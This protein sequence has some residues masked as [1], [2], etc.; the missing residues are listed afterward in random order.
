ME[1]CADHIRKLHR[2]DIRILKSLEYLMERY[3]LVPLEEIAS[4]TRLSQQEVDFRIR[5]LVELGMVRYK[6]IPYPGYALLFN[7]YDSLALY[8]LTKK[9][10]ISSLGTIIGEGKES[11]VYEGMGLGTLV[12]KLHRIGQRSFHTIRKNRDLIP[13]KGHCPWI[14]ASRYSAEREYAALTHLHQVISVPVPIAINRNCIAMSEIPGATLNRC[15]LTEPEETL[16]TILNQTRI[17]FQNGYIHG[18]LSEYNI[19]FT[20]SKV[21][22]IDWPQWVEPSHENASEILVHDIQTVLAH[23]TRKYACNITCSEAMEV[24]TQ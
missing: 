6:A 4:N 8:A 22:I 15:T 1:L 17:A 16:A 20:G 21:V 5:T 3:A 12:L 13:D 9:N 23:F 19:M 2:Y 10:I 11:K 18:D 24:V 14:F 7:G